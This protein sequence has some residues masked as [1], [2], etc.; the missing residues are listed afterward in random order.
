MP[1]QVPDTCTRLGTFGT[2]KGKLIY[3]PGGVWYIT[4]ATPTS[5]LLNTQH[6]PKAKYDSDVCS[7][8][9]ETQISDQPPGRLEAESGE[10]VREFCELVK[11]GAHAKPKQKTE[12]K[13]RRIRAEY[14]RS[15]GPEASL[16]AIPL[17]CN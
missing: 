14:T 2:P 5:H 7:E 9:T 17:A 12:H 11:C 13:P 16:A 6:G 1:H 4:L 10:I 3:V 15:E 8:Y